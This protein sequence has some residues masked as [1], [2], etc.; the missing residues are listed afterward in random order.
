MKQK[1][2]NGTF[3]YT[4]ISI[5][6]GFVIGALL[7]SLI[8][9]SPAIAYGKLFHGIFGRPKF[10]TYSVVYAA[11][12]IFTGLSVA[13]SFRTGIFNIGA[14]GQYVMGS[15]AAVVIGILCPLPPVLHA[16]VCILAAAAAGGLWGMLIGFLK[17]KKGINEV[18]SYIM[19]NWIAFYFSNYIINLKMIHT[20]Q[21]ADASRN[22]AEGAMI[23]MP[24]VFAGLT[25]C[26]D[27]HWGIPL[28]VLAAVAIW[29]I[30]TKTTFGYQL[31]A[32][33]FSRTA[34]EYAGINANRVFL[35]S[36]AIS[37]VLSGLGG[38]I[39][40]LGMAGRVAQFA[41]QEQY[42]FQGI[43]VS[44]IAGTHPIGCI[45][46]GLFYGAMKYGGNK[47]TVVNVP[48]EVVNIIMGIIVVFIAIAPVFRAIFLRMTQKK[49]GKA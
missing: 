35:I 27:V 10:M 8:G 30:M 11:P 28:A 48:T 5:V 42:G 18:L 15:L 45:F 22:V 17:V 19:F 49:E 6:I 21:G 33:G 24:S 26:S 29:F 46:A 20:D 1:I 47:L 23:K 13:F 12:L 31:R 14:E 4:L 40:T 38:A 39:Q 25:G 3:L 34:A 37:G 2:L 32:V 9:V 43:T 36:M 7:L 44:L 41:A 16:I